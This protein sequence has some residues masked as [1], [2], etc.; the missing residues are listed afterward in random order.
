MR[1]FA[2]SRLVIATHNEGKLREFAALLALYASNIVSAGSLQLPEPEETGN[3]FAE[4][5]GLKAC[6]A[7][8]ISG[9]IALADDSGLCVAA[10]N[11]APGIYSARWGGPWQRF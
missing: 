8:K 1:R 3:T 4:N 11:D 7:A 2:G 5:A 9:S 10:L 6:A